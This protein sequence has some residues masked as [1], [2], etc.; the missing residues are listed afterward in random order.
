M[1]SLKGFMGLLNR[2]GLKRTPFSFCVVGGR[3]SSARKSYHYAE[4]QQVPATPKKIGR[5]EEKYKR[6]KE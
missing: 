5:F 1:N 3:R 6:K 2:N 4:L